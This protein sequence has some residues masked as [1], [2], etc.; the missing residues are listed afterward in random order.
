MADMSQMKGR[1]R[2]IMTDSRYAGLSLAPKL[3]V[4]TVLAAVLAVTPMLTAQPE[5]REF[6][7]EPISLT[8][9]DADVRDVLTTFSTL[10]GMEIL[11]GPGVRGKVTKKVEQEPWDAVLVDIL[12]DLNLSYQLDDGRMIVRQVDEENRNEPSDPADVTAYMF[13]SGEISDVY[14]YVEDGAI[15]APIADHKVNPH[16]PPEM[17]EAGVSGMVVSELVIDEMGSVRMVEVLES[18]AEE[19]SKAATDAFEQ[20]TFTPATMDGK[21]VAVKYVVTVAFRL[22]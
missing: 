21:P 6:T 14:T 2:M 4:A 7:G 13:D 5:K 22:Q 1:I 3:L 19:L 20:W 12:E 18:P 11:V 9:E 17:R 16:Y 15:S 10:T 8:L